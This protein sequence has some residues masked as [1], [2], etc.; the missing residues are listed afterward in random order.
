M[1]SITVKRIYEPYEK[2]DGFRILVDRLWPR[3]QKKGSLQFNLWAKNIAPS[4]TLRK[5]FNHDLQKW[6]Q[7]QLRYQDELK[8]NKY[9]DDFL[10]EVK[11]H[12]RITLLYAAH[13]EEH[14]HAVVLQEFIN[15]AL[16]DA[17]S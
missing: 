5:W 3:G 2:N 12:K 11:D 4:P 8:Q 13:D 7:F 9:I 16:S 15:R 6:Q 17:K 10:K 14:N 1:P